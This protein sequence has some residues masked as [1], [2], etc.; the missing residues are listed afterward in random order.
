[1][2]IAFDATSG[3]RLTPPGTSYT[4]SH[5]CSGTNRILF[6]GAGSLNDTITSVTYGGTSMTLVAKS[7]YPGSGRIGTALY[8]LINPASGAN[9]IV[10]S[11]SASDNITIAAASYTGAKQ[12]AQPDANSTTNNAASSVTGSVTTVADNCWLV[13]AAV[14]DQN[15][16][17]AGSGT[18]MRQTDPN[19]SIG[20]SNAAKTPA[21]SHSLTFNISP[22]ASNGAV[23]A[24]FSPATASAPST[25]AL[26]FGHFA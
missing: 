13:M 21:G 26:M 14:N 19:Y 17:T 24:S 23:I 4:L 10:V 11:S 9:N 8:Y 6:V 5:T 25:D 3:G 18:T 22:S 12:S 15:N 16:F 2:A 1:M 20:D 7:S